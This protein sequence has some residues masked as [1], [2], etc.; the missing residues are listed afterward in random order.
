MGI[1]MSYQGKKNI[2]RITVS[3]CRGEREREREGWRTGRRGAQPFFVC[4]A[5]SVPAERHSKAFWM[6]PLALTWSPEAELLLLL[7]EEN[8]GRR[9]LRSGCGCK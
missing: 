7:L 6:L 2:P 8:K 3:V 4:V 5:L 9:A 1:E